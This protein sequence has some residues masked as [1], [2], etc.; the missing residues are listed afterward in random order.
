MKGFEINI[1]EEKINPAVNTGSVVIIL[2]T[3]RFSVSGRDTTGGISL[4][5][6]KRNLQEGDKI[7]IL[8]SEMTTCEEAVSTKPMDDQELL[9]EYFGLKEILTKEGVL[10]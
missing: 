8:P 3:S 5:W 1:N 4:D 10:P 6:G 7:K 2:E 9:K